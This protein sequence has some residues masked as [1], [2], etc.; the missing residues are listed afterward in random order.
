M[1]ATRLTKLFILSAFLHLVG[2]VTVSTKYGK[3]E[4][5]SISYSN[6]SGPFKSVTKF[7][8]VPFAAPP[9]G[10]LRFKA[11]QPL[12]EWKPNVRLAKKH[13]DVCLQGE[14]PLN[15]G[16]Q[17]IC[18]LKYLFLGRILAGWQIIFM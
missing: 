13:G 12:K 15:R 18:S 10:E 8:G 17:R 4:G 9:I 1:L 11:P 5:L 7:L 3:I 2:S 16:T 14:R 6:A